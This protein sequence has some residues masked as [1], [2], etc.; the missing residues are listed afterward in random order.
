MRIVGK[1]GSWWLAKAYYAEATP[2]DIVV[3]GSSQLGALQGADAYVFDRRVDITGDHRS[4]VLEG[5]LRGFLNKRFRVLV[6]GLPGMMISDQLVISRALF[7]KQFKPQLV[8]ICFSPRDFI[9]NTCSSPVRTEPFMFFARYAHLESLGDLFQQGF[10]PYDLIAIL[11][12]R[13]QSILLRTETYNGNSDKVL[14]LPVANPFERINPGEI[15][16][17]SGTGYFFTIILLNTN[18]DTKSDLS[19]A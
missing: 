13:S 4:Y 19:A 9:D 15:I 1:I 7:S 12:L 8:A 17:G 3:L 6:G 16:I 10:N 2:P 18:E 11:P 5:D 14:S